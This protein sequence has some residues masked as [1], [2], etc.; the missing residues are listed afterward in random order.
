MGNCRVLKFGT[1]PAVAKGLLCGGLAACA[2]TVLI[3]LL[4]DALGHPPANEAVG[5]AVGILWSF[6]VNLPTALL[7]SFLGVDWHLGSRADLTT[8]QRLSTVGTNA[9]LFG[10]L[11]SVAACLKSF[12]TA[13]GQKGAKRVSQ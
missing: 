11:G 3:Q 10:I 2:M 8:L 9:L 12:G 5:L 4:F 6:V 7:C 13:R 1:W